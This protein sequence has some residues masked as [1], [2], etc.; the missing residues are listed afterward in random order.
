[1]QRGSSLEGAV[2]TRGRS[3]AQQM[4]FSGLRFYKTPQSPAALQWES[5]SKSGFAHDPLGGTQVLCGKI[6][7]V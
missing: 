2:V 4:F 3:S 5:G 1:M 6:A 7:A